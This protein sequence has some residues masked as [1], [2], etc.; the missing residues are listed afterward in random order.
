VGVLEYTVKANGYDDITGWS[1]H[2]HHHRSSS[3]QVVAAARHEGRSCA[4]GKA[5]DA[6]RC[7][8]VVRSRPRCQSDDPEKTPS[9]A[10]E[11]PAAMR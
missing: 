6:E 2:H 4:S 8:Q 9:L 11:D 5:S 1:S 7:T 3:L 10:A